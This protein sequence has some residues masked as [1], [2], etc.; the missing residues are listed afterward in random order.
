MQLK[1][2]FFLPRPGVH[3]A[4]VFL[5]LVKKYFKDFIES[6]FLLY[7]QAKQDKGTSKKYR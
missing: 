6:I 4:S 2:L 5:F 1:I 3:H 7:L